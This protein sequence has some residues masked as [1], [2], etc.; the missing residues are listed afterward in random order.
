M[1]NHY[2]SAGSRQLVLKLELGDRQVCDSLLYVNDRLYV[3][4]TPELRTNAIKEA[5]DTPAEGHTGRSSTYDRRDRCRFHIN[6]RVASCI[7]NLP[8]KWILN[9]LTSVKTSAGAFESNGVLH[10]S[11]SAQSDSQS[12]SSDMA[13]C[14][15]LHRQHSPPSGKDPLFTLHC[16]RPSTNERAMEMMAS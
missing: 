14:S 15:S 4:E 1:V 10:G 13:A 16:F 7:K 8:I 3:P 5:H 6:L 2:P 11:R 12:S 9:L